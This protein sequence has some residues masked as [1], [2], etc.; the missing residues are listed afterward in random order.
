MDRV[1]DIAAKVEVLVVG[2]AILQLQRHIAA[3]SL[4]DATANKE[5]I[6]RLVDQGEAGHGYIKIGS[7]PACIGVPERP[8]CCQEARPCSDGPL[9]ADGEAKRGKVPIHIAKGIVDEHAQHD[10]GTHLNVVASG[11][12]AL[13][14]LKTNVRGSG[15]QLRSA[16]TVS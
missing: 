5:A 3:Q 1:V 13:Y 16:N 7:C 4:L 15:G 9:V 14:P 11:Q 10:V 6:E 8:C 12:D 2:E